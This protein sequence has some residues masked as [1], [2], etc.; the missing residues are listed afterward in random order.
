MPSL[1]EMKLDELRDMGIDD[2][3]VDEMDL[4]DVIRLLQRLKLG[5]GN[6]P[7]LKSHTLESLTKLNDETGRYALKAVLSI[8]N[9]LDE[10][11]QR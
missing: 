9:R 10:P 5:V 8:A 11:V 6:N 1:P 2:Q 4:A 7:T 3:M